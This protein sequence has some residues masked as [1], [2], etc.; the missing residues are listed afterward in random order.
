MPLHCCVRHTS[1][2]HCMQRPMYMP[3]TCTMCLHPDDLHRWIGRSIDTY[4]ALLTLYMRSNGVLNSMCSCRGYFASP[5]IFRFTYLLG[6]NSK[7][8]LLCRV[9]TCSYN[10][11][12]RY[13]SFRNSM[14]AL[15][16][17]ATLVTQGRST[18]AYHAQVVRGRLQMKQTRKAC[19]CCVDIPAC[20][21]MSKASGCRQA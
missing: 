19:R 13:A 15:P 9:S 1:H 17:G 10:M 6:H 16:W 20:G 5:C 18:G 2:H 11:F 14:P 4:D 21:Q 3:L 7:A 8:H 12:C